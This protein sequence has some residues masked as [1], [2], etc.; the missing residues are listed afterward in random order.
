MP[1]PTKERILRKYW[2]LR[3]AEREGIANPV[4]SNSRNGLMKT[5]KSSA[6]AVATPDSLYGAYRI[7]Q[8]VGKLILGQPHRMDVL[9]SRAPDDRRAIETSLLKIFTSSSDESERRRA[10]DALEEYGFVARQC[11]SML[12]APDAFERTSATRALGEIKAASALPFLLE[13]LYDHESIVRNQAV[14]S[15]GELK[16][17]R[18]IGALLDMARQH[19]DVPGSLVSRAL[20]ACSVEDRLFDVSSLE[21]LNRG[22]SS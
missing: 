9:S 4:G 16:L 13:A 18:A 14:V 19:P 3:A 8:E 10:C 6:M 12:L 15:I 5:R 20:S 7:D 21:A 22:G 2:R 17:P 11:A 1:K